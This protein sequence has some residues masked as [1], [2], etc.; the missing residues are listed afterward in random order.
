MM[1]KTCLTVAC[2]L[3]AFA[4]NGIAQITTVANTGDVRLLTEPSGERDGDNG[5]NTITGRL[6]GLNTGG[7]DNFVVYQFDDLSAVSGSSVSGATINVGVAQGF[8][9]ANHG[10]LEDLINVGELALPNLSLIHI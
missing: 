3:A 10:T 5:G 2:C 8:A 9:N 7:I 4:A 1:K 6:I